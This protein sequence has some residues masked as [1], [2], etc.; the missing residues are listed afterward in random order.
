MK[1]PTHKTKPPC[2]PR[3]LTDATLIELHAK[4]WLQKDIARRFGTST[5]KVCR[6][7]KQLGLVWRLGRS[8]FNGDSVTS[9]VPYWISLE[10][11]EYYKNPRWREE[12]ESKP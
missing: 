10:V 7:S 5:T 12:E 3:E 6:R 8:A 4:G 9:A 2:K 11:V 1:Y